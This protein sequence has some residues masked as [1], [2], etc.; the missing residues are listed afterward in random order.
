[1]DKF[2]YL[3]CAEKKEDIIFKPKILKFMP[4]YF[5][6]K[7]I[8]KSNPI[9]INSIE[10]LGINGYNITLPILKCEIEGQKAELVL[11][12]TIAELDNM[13]V[14]SF[15]STD[16][17]TP[18]ECNLIFLD[19]K[20]ILKFF[21]FEA[22]KKILKF[23]NKDI[24]YTEFLIIDNEDS[25]STY[26]ILNL[27]YEEI[28]YL[29]LYTTRSEYFNDFIDKIYSDTGLNVQTINKNNQVMKE[30][31]IIINLSKSN[32]INFDYFYKRGA[33]FFDLSGNSERTLDLLRKRNDLNVIDDL[34]FNC[35]TKNIKNNILET[36]LYIK[37]SVF[38]D[39][40]DCGI[41]PQPK[42]SIMKISLKNKLNIIGFCQYG[43]II[44][45]YKS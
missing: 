33:V 14:I 19:G 45:D 41:C 11:K 13:E 38:K 12:N 1:M 36:V 23:I 43:N 39:F 20:R 24:K 27:I 42:N 21:I 10:Y 6:D 32:D 4:K 37:E 9:I 22:I 2:A 35:D 16:I 15:T 26:N 30:A 40:I 7:Y 8:I 44:R 31:D 34:I 28:N 25:D 29:T 18:L 5:K 17:K 3:K